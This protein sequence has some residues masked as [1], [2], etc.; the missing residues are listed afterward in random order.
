MK[1]EGDAGFQDAV[2]N[3]GSQVIRAALSADSAPLDAF[4]R[5]VVS[6][7]PL[8]ARGRRSIRQ[9]DEFTMKLFVGFVEIGNSYEALDSIGRLARRAPPRVAAVSRTSYL[10]FCVECHLSEMYI[11]QQRILA[12]LTLI[13]RAYR[14]DPHRAVLQELVDRLT[15]SVKRVFSGIVMARGAHVHEKRHG[16]EELDRLLMLDVLAEDHPALAQ[17]RNAAFREVRHKKIAWMADNNDA[18][19]KLLA[20]ILGFLKPALFLEDN[21]VRF[22]AQLRSGRSR[23]RGK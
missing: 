6:G 3:A 22:P 8:T 23:P 17:V 9:D 20:T 12:Y 18:V 1:L 19:A 7:A 10:R 21:S 4:L 14:C 16:D 13:V 15:Q 11:L 5:N 2:I